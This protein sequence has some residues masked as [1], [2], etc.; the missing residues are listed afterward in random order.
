M[1]MQYPNEKFVSI[2]KH[3]ATKCQIKIN[4][5]FKFVFFF[6]LLQA[7]MDLPPDKAKQLKNYDNKKK[8]DIICDQVSKQMHH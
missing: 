2:K 5:H 6:C 7:S 3:L 4:F 1:E 8:W